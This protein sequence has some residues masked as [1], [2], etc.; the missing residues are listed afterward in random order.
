MIN[1]TVG[2]RVPWVGFDKSQETDHGPK[3]YNAGRLDCLP[4][5]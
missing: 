4:G 2:T 5:S 1:L 3:S